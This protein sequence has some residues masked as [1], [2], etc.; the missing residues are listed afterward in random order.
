MLTD[1]LT[2]LSVAHAH[3]IARKL[4]VYEGFHD[5]LEGFCPCELIPDLGEDD[6]LLV[7]A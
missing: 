5:W 1:L 2:R 4:G 7:T 3:W 6:L